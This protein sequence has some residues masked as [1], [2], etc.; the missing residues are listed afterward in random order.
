MEQI[1]AV[2]VLGCIVNVYA[3]WH[4]SHLLTF[5]LVLFSLSLLSI[6]GLMLWG[7]GLRTDRV[8]IALSQLW[9]AHLF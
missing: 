2:A 8:L 4:V 1:V 6:Y 7:L 9:I 3:M 5:C